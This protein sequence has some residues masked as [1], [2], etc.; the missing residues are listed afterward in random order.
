M[1]MVKLTIDGRDVLAPEESTILQAAK[2]AGIGIPTLC[3]H[4]RLK[5]IGSCG[6]CIVE[7]DG[8]AAPVISCDTL[9]SEGMSVITRSERLSGTHD[10]T[11]LTFRMGP[12]PKDTSIMSIYLQQVGKGTTWFDDMEVKMLR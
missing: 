2:N 4:E 3:F 1:S 5:P 7:V 8:K 12:P 9:V 11:K 10:W 6:M